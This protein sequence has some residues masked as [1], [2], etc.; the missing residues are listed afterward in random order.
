LFPEKDA[1][2]GRNQIGKWGTV[3]LTGCGTGAG[4]NIEVRKVKSKS[5]LL[6]IT[7]ASVFLGL[8]LAA[9]FKAAQYNDIAS[10]EQVQELADHL[11]QDKIEME[12]LRKIIADT[13]RNQALL[14]EARIEAGLVDLKGPGVTVTLNA[15]PKSSRSGENPNLYVISDEDLLKVVNELK[16]AGAE[17]ISVNNQRIIA[18][19]EIRQAGPHILV[20]IKKIA[21]PY[22][23][24]G[25]GNPDVL[26]SSLRIKGGIIETFQAGG[27]QIK[28]EKSPS[29]K[30]PAYDGEIK[31]EFADPIKDNE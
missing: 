19:S 8:M 15:S 16:A 25:I 1:K 13:S 17:A 26:D 22:V 12:R 2:N 7:L 20:N 30:V 4:E 3:W 14:G 29:L 18:M 10:S 24:T 21:P 5:G 9:Q 31:Y 28:I 23:I 6:I 27:Y 11:E